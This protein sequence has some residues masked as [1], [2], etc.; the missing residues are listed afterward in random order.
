LQVARQRNEASI[1][2]RVRLYLSALCFSELAP[3]LPY[4]CRAV[5]CGFRFVCA[6]MKESGALLE[7]GIPPQARWGRGGVERV[8]YGNLRYQVTRIHRDGVLVLSFT[9]S[10]VLLVV[11]SRSSTPYAHDG[12]GCGRNRVVGAVFCGA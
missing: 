12:V 8:S 6:C 10:V 2:A 3:P 11:L 4:R 5:W 9:L 7:S 1:R